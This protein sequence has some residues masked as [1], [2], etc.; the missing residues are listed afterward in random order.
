LETATE[1]KRGIS[2]LADVSVFGDPLFV[3][4][5]GSETVDIYRVL[6]HMA[7]RG[8]ALIGLQKPPAVHLCVTLRHTQP[9]VAARFLSDLRAS[10][11][12]VKATPKEKGGMAPMYGLA[13]T[14]PFRGV[15]G[16]LLKK[17]LDLLYEP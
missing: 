3:I 2:E 14:V 5:F 13:N 8:W 16:D 11:D 9:G 12:E 17:Y 1:I 15:V 7:H 4:A 10:L 6:D